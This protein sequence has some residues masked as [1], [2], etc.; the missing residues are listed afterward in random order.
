MKPIFVL[1]SWLKRHRFYATGLQETIYIKCYFLF[2]HSS[3]WEGGDTS[4][5]LF[6]E[7]RVHS[8]AVIAQLLTLKFT[9]WGLSMMTLFIITSNIIKI[10]IVILITTKRNK[11]INEVESLKY[12]SELTKNRSQFCLEIMAKEASLYATGCQEIIYKLLLFYLNIL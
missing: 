6:L 7:Q 9:F 8:S 4:A 12:I 11:K 10:F 1:R 3:V 5:A 2:K